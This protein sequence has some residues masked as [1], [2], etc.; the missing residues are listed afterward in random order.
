LI[1]F[2]GRPFGPA[3]FGPV[4]DLEAEPQAQT[5]RE[6]QSRR[7]DARSYIEER[8]PKLPQE[9]KLYK[10]GEVAGRSGFSTQVISTWCMLGLLRETT[11]TPTG[12]RL[13]DESIFKRLS[14][15]RDL[16]K[17]GYTLR[18]IRETFIKDRL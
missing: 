6:P 12:R 10:I 11:R 9:K 13:F 4:F 16:N 2:L 15:I 17:Q 8:A 14:L 3:L 5:R 18:D 7:Q 1:G